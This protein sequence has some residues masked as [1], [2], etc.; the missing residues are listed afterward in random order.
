VGGSGG[1]LGKEI[2][3]ECNALSKA[4]FGAYRPIVRKDLGDPIGINVDL[5]AVGRILVR[6]TSE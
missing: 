5:D 6:L 4:D 2:A 1:A 3:F